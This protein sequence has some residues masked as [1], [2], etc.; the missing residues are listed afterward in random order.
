MERRRLPVSGVFTFLACVLVAST[1]LFAEG[2]TPARVETVEITG[3]KGLTLLADYRAPIS[4]RR[5]APAVL[6]VHGVLQTGK[7]LVVRPLAELLA[8]KGY[9][10]L[11]ITL[12]HGVTRRTDPLTCDSLHIFALEDSVPEIRTWLKWLRDRGHPS[13]VLMGHSLGANQ[14][15]YYA[16]KAGD[17]YVRALVSIALVQSGREHLIRLFERTKGKNFDGVVIEAQRLAATG[18][19][20]RLLTVPFFACSQ[21]RVSVRAFLSYFGPDAPG[22]PATLLPSVRIPYLAAHGSA[23]TRASALAPEVRVLQRGNTA[24]RWTEIQAADHFF[25]EFLAEDLAEAVESFLENLR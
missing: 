2:V 22:K 16:V 13:A 11:S 5:S 3:P 14:V 12:S 6:L 10:T 18:N 7:H 1:P 19:E 17:I 4:P 9:P 25:R 8:R 23:D 20:E 15:L 24:F 21:A